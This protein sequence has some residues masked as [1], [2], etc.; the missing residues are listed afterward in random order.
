MDILFP[1][2]KKKW[3]EEGFI[4]QN[5]EGKYI[6]GQGPFSY[7]SQ[8][9]NQSLYRSDFFLEDKKPWI[10]PSLVWKANKEELGLFLFDSKPWRTCKKNKLFLFERSQAPSF[11]AYQE[12]FFQIQQAIQK[13]FFKKIVPIFCETFLERVQLIFFL[14]N[15]F[16]NTVLFSQAYLYGFWSKGSGILGCTPEVLFSKEGGCL[17]TMALAGTASHPGP[18]L[19]KDSKELKEHYF[20]VKDIQESL[21]N[22]P[23]QWNKDIIY[24]MLFPPLK[25]LRT[26]LKGKVTFPISF[27]QLCKALHPTSALGGYPKKQ[28][29]ICLKKQ[30]EKKKKRYFGS[31]F[32]FFEDSE[33]AFCVIA[34]RA[35]EWS[36][37]GSVIYS[38]GGLVKES[39]LQKEWQELFLKR[40]QVKSFFL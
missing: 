33:T 17:Q 22:F 29:L 11:I 38:G 35:L 16:K 5:P 19:L 24:E 2:N 6:L 18:S 13:G 40:Q 34:L 30:S 23:I 21:E 8:P 3:L 37:L 32:G 28:A 20:V 4:L 31:P 14:Q 15:L 27:E 36:P 39:L 25:H 12:C 1:L 10:K 7:S 9:K 26:D